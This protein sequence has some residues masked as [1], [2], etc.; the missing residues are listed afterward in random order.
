MIW[1]RNVYWRLHKKRDTWYIHTYISYVTT[2]SLWFWIYGYLWLLVKA[3]LVW[4][5]WVISSVRDFGRSLG[6]LLAEPSSWVYSKHLRSWWFW[7][8]WRVF[9]Q[10]D[11]GHQSRHLSCW[12]GPMARNLLK[13][14]HKAASLGQNLSP[15]API[16]G[17]H[18]YESWPKLFL[19]NYIYVCIYIYIYY[20]FL[21][22]YITKL[23]SMKMTTN[24]NA[25]KQISS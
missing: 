3:S 4:A 22:L 19:M 15:P 2:N 8:I 14:G 13:A 23:L 10:N 17:W 11:A 12:G 25:I 6:W 7:K 16:L 1:H 24:M 21:I 9:R 5:T 20:C 18:G